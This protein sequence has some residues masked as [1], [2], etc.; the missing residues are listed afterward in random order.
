MWVEPAVFLIVLF[1]IYSDKLFNV[2]CLY[3]HDPVHY[4]FYSVHNT[5]Y[6]DHGA[7]LNSIYYQLYY[8]NHDGGRNLY[9]TKY[10]DH[11]V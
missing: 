7:H 4:C 3:H 6:H 1:D 10:Y 9:D 2:V 11:G 8:N 5:K